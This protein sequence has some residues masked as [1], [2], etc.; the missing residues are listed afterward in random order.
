MNRIVTLI[1][2]FGWDDAY[3]GAVKGAILTVNPDVTIVDI[4]HGI[5]PHSILDA[6]LCLRAAYA[7]FPPRTVHVVVVDPGVGGSRRGL[8]VTSEHHLFV[9]PDNGIF[10]FVR[11]DMDAS[12]CFELTA[13]HYFNREISP[14]FHA[15]DI[16][17]PVAG[18]L[19]RGIAPENFGEPVN[20]PVRLRLPQPV[21]GQGR[22]D[23]HILRIDRF[24]NLITSIREAQ[25]QQV[26]AGTGVRCLVGEETVPVP[27]GRYYAEVNK[28]EAC[29][30][31]GSGGLVEVAVNQ[32]RAQAKYSAR[33]G[34]R[35]A[36]IAAG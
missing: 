4:T 10:T 18:W 24:G 14:T 35:V 21:L 31:I 28:G 11:E 7:H 30:L 16:F 15:R 25:V 29:A 22:I 3:A 17:G 20:D 33:V 5:P 12:G 32:G 27:M 26:F 19:T 9:G 34:M 23:G 1:T 13:S 6:A 36:L 2:D 8:L